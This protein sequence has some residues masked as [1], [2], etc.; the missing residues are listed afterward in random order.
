MIACILLSAGSSRRFGSPKALARL[1]GETV[2]EHLQKL[3]LK[4]Q[5]CEI[6]VVLGAQ[7][8]RIKPHLLNHKRVKVVQNKDYKSGQT[9][10][11]KAGLRNISDGV[12][13]VMVLPVDYPFVQEETI[14]ALIRFFS[15]HAPLIVAPAFG[16]RKGHPPLFSTRLRNEFLALDNAR[17]L[18]TVMRARR[19]ET[20]I[21]PVRDAGVLKTFN[22]RV[23]LE[24]LKSDYLKTTT[25]AV[26]LAR[27]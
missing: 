18:N 7:A 9:S 10:S 24:R 2:I 17:G 26:K 20:F 15:D 16:G 4:T 11:V 1:N 6:I 12:R 5:L 8:G 23:E 14:D 3:L 21:L 13:G 27:T 25:E 19:D 22:T